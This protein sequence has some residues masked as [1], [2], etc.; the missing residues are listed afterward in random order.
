MTYHP[1]S[2]FIQ[3]FRR[4]SSVGGISSR[5]DFR[6]LFLQRLIFSESILTF[7][8][9]R[10]PVS[11]PELRNWRKGSLWRYVSNRHVVQST[12]LPLKEDP[13]DGS[14]WS[15][16]GYQS[17]LFSVNPKIDLRL[18][19][20]VNRVRGNKIGK[21]KGGRAEEDAD[22]RPTRKNLYIQ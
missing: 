14:L 20:W 17:E 13:P 21:G 4:G 10:V 9:I 5:V 19:K 12:S 15:F 8:R 18:E 3:K 11:L 2:L 22:K 6:G 7:I 1:V 16:N